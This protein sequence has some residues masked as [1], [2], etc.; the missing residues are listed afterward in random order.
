MRPDMIPSTSPVIYFDRTLKIRGVDVYLRV[1][2]TANTFTFNTS[3]TLSP[4]EKVSFAQYMQNEGFLDDPASGNFSDQ[5]EH[6][7]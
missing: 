3:R 7:S 5:I 4:A 1:F 2:P 6:V